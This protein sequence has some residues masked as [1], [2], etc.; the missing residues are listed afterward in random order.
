MN[1]VE[2]EGFDKF[3]TASLSSKGGTA[4]Y[5]NNKF[6]SLER[7]DLNIKNEEYESTWLEIKNSKSKN[8]IT[9][10]IYRHPHY[11]FE[12][13]FKYLENCLEKIAKENKEVYIC[14]DFNFDLLKIDSDSHTQNFFNLLCSYGFLPHVLQPTRVTGSSATVIDNIFSN[15]IKNEVSSGNIL[16]TLSEHF[17]QFVS[18]NRGTIDYKKINM[19]RRDYSKYSTES[20][21]DDVS[22]QNWNY[23]LNNVH[24]SFKDFYLKLDGCVERHAPLKK[25][26]PK[27]IRSINKPWLSHE[28]LKMIKIRNKVFARVK[29]QP[30]NLNSKRLYN[31][32]RNRVNRELKKLKKNYY[33]DYFAENINNIKKTWDG[34]RKI[35]NIK[36]I[37]SKSSQLKIGGKIVDNDKLIASHFNNFFVNVGPNTENTIPKVPNISPSKFLKNRIQYNFVIAHIS[38]E[39]ILDIV[40]ALDNKSSGP[41]SIPLK[42]LSQIPDLI[43]IPLAYIINL[44]FT[45]GEYPNLLKIV[46]VIPIH[47]GGS[48]QDVNNF[49]PISLLSIFD[50]IIEKITHKDCIH[51]LRKITFYFKISLD[52]EK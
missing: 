17:S 1:N 22:I 28:I 49:R 38:N 4:I 13:F 11:N 23:S 12:E 10:C 20:F 18:I 9:G 46:K 33:A 40:N 21:R 5:F 45:T 19:Y 31:L 29:R 25:L 41:S 34:I 44:S 47:K 48:T 26:T 42:L 14:G 37:S 27:D 39:E 32:L 43:I 36:K 16:L 7:I 30:N 35:V 6:D 8:I 15:N 51:S 24:E 3:H 50:K 52:L 2:I